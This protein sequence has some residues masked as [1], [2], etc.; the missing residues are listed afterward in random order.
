M[1]RRS[2]TEGAPQASTPQA[3]T[4]QA[5]TAQAGTPPA[6]A[7][8]AW[9]FLDTLVIEHSMATDTG[10]RVLEMTLPVGA[11][12]P[13][14]MHR[15]YDDSFFLLEGQVIM[16]CGAELTLVGPGCWVSTPRG[17]PHAFRVVGVRPA[18]MLVVLENDSFAELI[19]D[20]GEP[21]GSPA[22]PEAG[23]GPGTGDVFR[24]FAARDVTV[25]G[26]SLS[27]QE[28]DAFLASRG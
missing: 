6:G 12:P 19:R 10:L 4:P 16:Q 25:L 14:H 1:T 22:L 9:W 23:R 11:A 18:R 28:A 26:P 20:L 5:S 3:G 2:S 8:S 7:V 17:T 13:M 24:A 15:D 27:D 21:A